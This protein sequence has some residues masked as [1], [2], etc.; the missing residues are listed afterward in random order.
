MVVDDAFPTELQ[1]RLTD[2]DD[3]LTQIEDVLKPLHSI[4]LTDIH[5][6]VF[7]AVYA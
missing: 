1:E 4:P 3:A 6:K 2:F 7:S 5:T